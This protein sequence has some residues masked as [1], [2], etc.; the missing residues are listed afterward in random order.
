MA[1][2][3]KK[4]KKIRRFGKLRFPDFPGYN[5][6]ILVRIYENA[7]DEKKKELDDEMTDY[8]KAIESKELKP[9]DSIL[10][11]AFHEKDPE[12]SP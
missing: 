12:V 6:K 11:L 2:N 9:G 4:L 8:F 5:E 7:S 1:L 10:K 3:T